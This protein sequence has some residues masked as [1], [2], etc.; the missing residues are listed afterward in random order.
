[1]QKIFLTIVLA[2]FAATSCQPV[3]DSG[4]AAQKQALLTEGKTIFE[5][6]CA[7]CHDLPDPKSHNDQ[8][9]IGIMNVMAPK[10]KLTDKQSELVYNYVTSVN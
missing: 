7:R 5:N 8:E 3:A 4:N 6:S 1:M 9:W 2:A 10:A